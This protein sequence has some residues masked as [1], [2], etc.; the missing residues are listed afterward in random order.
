MKTLAIALATALVA[1][2][3]V[4]TWRGAELADRQDRLLQAVLDQAAAEHEAERLRDELDRT[5]S[6][7]QAAEIRECGGLGRLGSEAQI[8]FIKNGQLLSSTPEGDPVEC[9]LQVKEDFLS[10]G[11]LGDRVLVGNKVFRNAS[12]TTVKPGVWSRPEGK[13]LIYTA[14]N[15]RRLMKVSISGGPPEDISFL[16]QHDDVVYHPAGTHI[17]ASG[18]NER[19]KYG[20]FIATNVGTEHFIVARGESTESISGLT[21]SHD[22]RHLFFVA[23]HGDETHLHDLRLESGQASS[24][25]IHPVSEVT[26]R[27]LS[28][29]SS[30][31]S[32]PV[33][34]P[35]TRKP[36][37]SFV[38]GDCSASTKT[39]VWH[40]G[41]PE[42]LEWPVEKQ[43]PIPIGWLPDGRMVVEVTMQG[44]CAGGGSLEVWDPDE[45]T[46]TTISPFV[47]FPSGVDLRVSLPKAP[48]PP[49]PAQEV[50]A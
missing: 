9:L 26:L 49:V 34:S 50:P 29:S 16:R 45:S 43:A 25:Q 6:D 2:A 12:S 14:S 20:I 35:F 28:V 42:E 27:T 44:Y 33:V 40:G 37:V 24:N 31:I 32:T 23:Q 36:L 41:Q 8:T 1:G 17:A 11:P 13:S 10:W 47:Q 4:Y 38:E 46:R 15:G 48:D 39:F 30:D 7:L 18:R 19:G 21:F 22:G 5:R 3:A